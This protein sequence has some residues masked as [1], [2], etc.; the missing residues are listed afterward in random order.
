M[1]TR[2]RSFSL[3]VLCLIAFSVTAHA[4]NRTVGAN[5]F[6]LDDGSGRT[7]TL[8]TPAPGAWP[9]GTNFNWVIPI[10][11]VS[12]AVSGFGP[13][14]VSNAAPVAPNEFL[15]WNGSGLGTWEVTSSLDAGPIT[16]TTAGNPAT[17]LSINQ[18][19]ISAGSISPTPVASGGTIPTNVS[20]VIVASEGTAATATAT[21]PAG[22]E[23]QILFVTTADPDGVTITV[24]GNPV[25]VDDSEVGVFAFIGGIW[26]LAH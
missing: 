9:A 11:P 22:V 12:G 13:R 2:T 19:R 5:K 14:G 20:T 21:L 16:V 1:T 8:Q 15:R 23:G 18:G 10:P 7:L 4:Q 24:G 6:I 17:A 26:R 25:N 3:A